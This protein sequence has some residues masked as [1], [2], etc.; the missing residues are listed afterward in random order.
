M[1]VIN[2][3]QCFLPYQG[4]IR[5]VFHFQFICKYFQF[6]PIRFFL[7]RKGLIKGISTFFLPHNPEFEK[8]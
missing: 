8:P 6:G 3:F 2:I 7:S 4:Q 1:V 5:H